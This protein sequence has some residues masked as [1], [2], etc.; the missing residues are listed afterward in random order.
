MHGNGIFRNQEHIHLFSQEEDPDR[1]YAGDNANHN[2]KKTR[3]QAESHIMTDDPVF[4]ETQGFQCTDTGPLFFY[5]TIHGGNYGKDCDKKEHRHKDNR[6]CLPFLYLRLV[7][8]PGNRLPAVRYG[9]DPAAG[10]LQIFPR[11]CQLFRILRIHYDLRKYIII[12]DPELRVQSFQE[13]LLLICGR[14]AVPDYIHKP[15]RG[16]QLNLIQVKRSLFLLYSASE[17]GTHPGKKFS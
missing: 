6:I 4:T 16:I 14:T 11:L 3:D 10:I 8:R 1:K 17:N 7:S 12:T 9:H 13:L 15:Q 5:K 2:S